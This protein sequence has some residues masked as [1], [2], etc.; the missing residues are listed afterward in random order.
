ML[1]QEDIDA[2]VACAVIEGG[3]GSLIY[4]DISVIP[5]AWLQ[6]LGVAGKA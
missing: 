1:T 5:L 2:R 3:F 4:T 6:K